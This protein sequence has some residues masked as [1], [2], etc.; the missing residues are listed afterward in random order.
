MSGMFQLLLFVACD[1]YLDLW[2]EDIFS[3]ISDRLS[4]QDGNGRDSDRSYARDRGYSRG[5]DRDYNRD[6]NRDRSRDR[7]RDYDRR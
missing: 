3:T 6:R 4:G 7:D 1:Y 2:H 5:R